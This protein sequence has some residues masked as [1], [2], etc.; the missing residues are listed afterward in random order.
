M[1]VNLKRV[2]TLKE[3]RAGRG[4]VVYWMSRDQRAEDN[5]A[6]LFAQEQALHARVPL[7][8][9]F[10]LVPEFLNATLRHYDFMLRGIEETMHALSQKN[11]PL[12]VIQGQ[13]RD[14]LPQILRKHDAWA[15]VSDFD[16]LRIKRK[17]KSEVSQT[18]SLPFYEIDAHN[19]VPCWHASSKQEYGAYTIRPK[20]RRALPE[21]LTP[22]PKLKPHPYRLSPSPPGVNITKLLTAL[23]IDASVREIGWIAPGKK[24]AMKVLRRFLGQGLAEYPLSRNDPNREGQSNLSAYLHFGQISAQRIALEVMDAKAPAQSKAAFLEEL[25]VRRELSD[26]YCFYTPDYDRFNGF[27]SWAK[28]TLGEHRRDTREYLY[29]LKDFEHAKTHDALWNAAQQEMTSTGKMHGY[30]RMYWAK[31]ILEWTA[32]PE[33]AMEFAIYLND[34]YSLDGRDPNGYTGIAWSVGGVHDRAWGERKVFGKIRYMSYNGCRSKFDI[35]AYVEKVPRQ[36]Q[37]RA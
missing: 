29:T 7:I 26:N 5:W 15:L 2:R 13:P 32:S 19:I 28:K 18:I 11:I 25:I 20:I 21:F 30:M 8:V 37:K 17:W 34:R 22:F 4:P 23:D 1:P 14:V 24:E 12:M 33:Q 35:K 16:P 9:I 10:C 36:E 31:K 6:L 27:P 3:G